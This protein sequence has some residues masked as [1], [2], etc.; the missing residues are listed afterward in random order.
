MVLL[1]LGMPIL[2]LILALALERLETSLLPARQVDLPDPA[3]ELRTYDRHGLPRRHPP[4]VTADGP[5][6]P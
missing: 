5:Y 6:S 4:R 2:V 1:V 3:E